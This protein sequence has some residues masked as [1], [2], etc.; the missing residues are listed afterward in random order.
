MLQQGGLIFFVFVMHLIVDLLTLPC[1]LCNCFYHVLRIDLFP[2]NGEILL[3]NDR[4]ITMVEPV[5]V[6][7]VNLSG[8]ASLNPC[9]NLMFWAQIK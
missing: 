2:D 8:K 5:N 7:P 3:S 1:D 6:E 9:L 4:L